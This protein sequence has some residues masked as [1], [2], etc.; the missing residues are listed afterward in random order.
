MTRFQSPWCRAENIFLHFKSKPRKGT[1]RPYTN[2]PGEGF[3]VTQSSDKDTTQTHH[4]QKRE[5]RCGIQTT[6]LE[7]SI[8]KG[9]V[10]HLSTRSHSNTSPPT[11]SSPSSR[12]PHKSDLNLPRHLLPL[13][14]MPPS[15]SSTNKTSNPP[16]YLI[17]FPLKI[18][19][20]LLTTF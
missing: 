12:Q 13:P 10:P 8:R 5:T 18:N 16:T 17:V 6:C 3:L 2:P 4:R 20:Y 7:C 11:S 19:A 14:D 1:T 9:P 15:N